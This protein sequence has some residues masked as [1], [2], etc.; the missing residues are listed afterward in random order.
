MRENKDLSFAGII[1]EDKERDAHCDRMAKDGIWGDHL[2]L[3]AMARLYGLNVRVHQA[4]EEPIDLKYQVAKD[5]AS[6]LQVAFYEQREH[7]DM[8]VRE[9]Y[10]LGQGTP[11]D[12]KHLP[13]LEEH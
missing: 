3:S 12:R 10:D 13:A 1:I 8:V 9:D 7:F 5:H 2:E 4:D 6:L 11:L